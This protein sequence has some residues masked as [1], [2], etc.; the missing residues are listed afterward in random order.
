MAAKV[1]GVLNAYSPITN[2]LSPYNNRYDQH[3]RI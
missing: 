2:G 1:L 3:P